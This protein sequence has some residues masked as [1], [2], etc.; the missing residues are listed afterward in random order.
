MFSSFWS[1]TIC[2]CSLLY[3]VLE[4]YPEQSN[5]SSHLL[6]PAKNL[7]LRKRES[8]RI[9]W[10]NWRTTWER[11]THNIE[12]QRDWRLFFFFFFKFWRLHNRGNPFILNFLS[13]STFFHGKNIQRP[14]IWSRTLLHFDVWT[15]P[16]NPPFPIH[17]TSGND[18]WYDIK[19]K[20][21][22]ACE[23]MMFSAILLCYYLLENPLIDLS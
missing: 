21:V 18:I 19:R 9:G 20:R 12:S 11:T 23:M 4:L 5:L 7:S 13:H 8:S 10:S 6:T 15:F 17:G 16:W 3:F 14:I 2:H 22:Q 1:D